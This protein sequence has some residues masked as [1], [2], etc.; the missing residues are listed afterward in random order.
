MRCSICV[1]QKY[2]K[3]SPLICSHP[4]RVMKIVT[5]RVTNNISSG[6]QRIETARVMKNVTARVT[7]NIINEA[8]NISG[9]NETTS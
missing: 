4:T 3:G 2:I 7:N 5:A 6:I 1:I 8:T 9:Y